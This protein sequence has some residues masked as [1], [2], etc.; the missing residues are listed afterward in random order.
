[1]PTVGTIRFSP[2]NDDS[3]TFCQLDF[4]ALKTNDGD[5]VLPVEVSILS[6]E[7]EGRPADN[8][9]AL[10]LEDR[11]GVNMVNRVRVLLAPFRYVR[12]RHSFPCS[13]GWMN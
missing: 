12:W 1:M 3:L 11:D 9:M 4:L 6:N 13:G 8:E 5:G 7:L 2:T 10:I